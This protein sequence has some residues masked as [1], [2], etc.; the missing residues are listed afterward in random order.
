MPVPMK[1]TSM[2]S[3][4]PGPQTRCSSNSEQHAPAF[5]IRSAAEILLSVTALPLA[6]LIMGAFIEFFG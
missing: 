2:P 6:M 4:A 1:A 3:P 5:R